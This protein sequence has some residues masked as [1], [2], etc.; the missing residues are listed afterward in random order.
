MRP[1]ERRTRHLA[2][3]LVPNISHDANDA[4]PILLFWLV[5]EGNAF[6]YSVFTGPIPLRHYIVNDYYGLGIFDVV[7]REESTVQERYPQGLEVV[8]CSHVVA[9][10][11]LIVI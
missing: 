2:I 7:I 5:A 9:R 3:G 4:H 1:P 8:R 11:G 10:S 6:S